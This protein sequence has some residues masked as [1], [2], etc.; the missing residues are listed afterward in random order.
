MGIFRTISNILRVRDLQANDPDL[1]NQNRDPICDYRGAIWVRELGAIT[2][3]FE[4]GPASWDATDIAQGNGA[5]PFLDPNTFQII[6]RIIAVS[7]DPAVAFSAAPV[8]FQLHNVALTP[9]AVPLYSFPVPPPPLML[10]LAVEDSYLATQ[11][12]GAQ[13][14]RWG[15]SS[16]RD[17]YTAGPTGN[18][19]I[20]LAHSV[21]I[22]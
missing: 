12:T 14:W 5:L 21:A 6:R 18:V 3:L 9:G 7:G 8:Y 20:N 16:T 17:T 10:D 13:R 11:V 1:E 2:G 22:L 15:F 19:S 4:S